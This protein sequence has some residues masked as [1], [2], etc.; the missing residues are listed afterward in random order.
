MKAL[1]FISL[2]LAPLSAEITFDN[3]PTAAGEAVLSDK[4]AVT[5]TQGASSQT[6][7]VLESPS[8][9]EPG[10]GPDVFRNRTFAFGS[11]A[12][13]FSAPVTVSVTKLFGTSAPAVQILPSGYG[14]T[15]SLSGDGRTVTFTLAQ[16]RYISVNFLSADNDH[17]PGGIV[18]HMLTIFADPLETDIP[19]PAEPGTITLGPSTTQQDITGADRL[20]VPTGYHNLLGQLTDGTI[21]LSANQQLYLQQ[22]AFL[23][24]KVTTPSNSHNV[25]IYGRGLFSGRDYD[26]ISGTGP[27]SHIE[28]KGNN[29]I[30]EGIHLADFDKHGIVPGPSATMR[31][32]KLWGWHYNND[33]FRPWGG[34]VDHCFLR[35]CDDGFYVGGNLVTVTDT[36]IW[37]S[38]NGA[39][40][41]CGWGS[42]DKPYNTADFVMSDCHVIHPE[43]N[44]IGN[45]NGIIASQLPYNASSTRILI[46]NLR[47][48]GDICALTNLKRN[49]SQPITGTAGGIS[50]IT[51][52]NIQVFGQQLTY[53]SNR[54][55]ATPSKSLIRGEQDFRIVHL[56]FDNVRINGDLVTEA[57][58]DSHFTI[59]PSTTSDIVF[60]DTST[61]YGVQLCSNPAFTANID[62]WTAYNDG[63]CDIIQS[64]TLGASSPG[65]V[66]ITNRSNK[67]TGVQQDILP[68]LIANGAGY[69]RYS[70]AALSAGGP[71]NAYVT[72]RLVDSAGTTYFPG[73]TI[74]LDSTGWQTSSRPSK[75]IDPS[76]L[77]AAYLYFETSSTALDD[78]HVDDFTLVKLDPGDAPR[79]K[80]DSMV[81]LPEGTRVTF[82]ADGLLGS[83]PWRLSKS[84]TIHSGAWTTVQS[85]SAQSGSITIVHDLAEPVP[86]SLFF[87]LEE[88][89]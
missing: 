43:W 62:G 19:S 73:S 60:T 68:V 5:I 9:T 39:V 20:F 47:V 24:A 80:L 29:S 37:Q 44:G 61:V 70:A 3:W 4:Y 65:A 53:N 63:I 25:R 67:W 18:R 31:N 54:T 58:K 10:G 78:F 42:P 79:L 16:S 74:I 51:F 28:I 77:T 46:E 89:R 57:N 38:F 72:L 34:T 84:P 75:H 12:S 14:I 2:L 22:G 45:N 81:P 36:V 23:V 49:E 52:R 6:L 85:H 32:I 87:R 33:G 17:A 76:G 1:L 40:V 41:T 55:Q 71:L 8:W 64:P 13:D 82:T 11:F 69:Y 88:E 48:D 7:K 50:N 83:G 56:L 15:S 27:A 59:D 35:T 86:D 26:W 21:V 30:V 66:T